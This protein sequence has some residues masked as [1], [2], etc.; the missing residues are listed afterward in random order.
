MHP[1][2]DTGRAAVAAVRAAPRAALFHRK[3]EW[4]SDHSIADRM[5]TYAGRCA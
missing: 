1:Y 4:A 2:I 3:D 5:T